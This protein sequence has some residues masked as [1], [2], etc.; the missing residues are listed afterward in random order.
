MEIEIDEEDWM[1]AEDDS[2]EDRDSA[3]PA[4]A[5]Q[6]TSSSARLDAVKD[7]SWGARALTSQA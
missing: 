7:G 6:A 5:R 1:L 4:P 2:D 3:Q